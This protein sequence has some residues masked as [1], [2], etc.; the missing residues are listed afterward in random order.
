M[1][2]LHFASRLDVLFLKCGLQKYAFQVVSFRVERKISLS[3]LAKMFKLILLCSLHPRA[4]ELCWRL[5]VSRLLA[6]V[7]KTTIANYDSMRS[8]SLP[9]IYRR[10]NP[11]ADLQRSYVKEVTQFKEYAIQNNDNHDLR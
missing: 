7:S 5:L 10:V 8:V 2:I 9:F 1:L 11:S 3:R 6:T 4:K